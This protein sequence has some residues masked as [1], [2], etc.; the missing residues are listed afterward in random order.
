MVTDKSAEIKKK[1]KK[2]E[3]KTLIFSLAYGTLKNIQL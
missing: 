1:Y 2:S 3:K